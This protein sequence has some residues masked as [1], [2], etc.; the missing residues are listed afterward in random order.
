M[1]RIK[2][3]LFKFLVWFLSP[4]TPSDTFIMKLSI[5][6][7]WWQITESLNSENGTWPGYCCLHQSGHME[8]HRKPLDQEHGASA[9]SRGQGVIT[10]FSASEPSAPGDS[11]KWMLNLLPS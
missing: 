2:L 3:S 11:V 1:L 8:V 10:K 6:Q 7:G 9:V 5:R 4:K